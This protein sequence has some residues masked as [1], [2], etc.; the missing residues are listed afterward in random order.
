[1]AKIAIF[2]KEKI[3]GVNA[4]S[5][6]EISGIP[7][8]TVI[9]KLRQIEKKEILHKEDNLYTLGRHYKKNIKDLEKVFIE[10]QID[11]CRFIAT[12]FELYKNKK[13]KS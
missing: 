12:F 1:M 5:I 7:R 6:S 11:L 4:S 9:R 3:V 2:T 13:L 10:N 8:A